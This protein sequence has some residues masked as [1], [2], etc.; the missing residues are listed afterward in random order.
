L[1]LDTEKPFNLEPFQQLIAKAYF[2]GRLE[3]VAILPFGNAKSTLLA[4][5]G[6]YHMLTTD[7]AECIVAAS[8]ADQAGIIFDQMAGLI[9]R[10][11][12]PLDARRAIRAI[13]HKPIP[14]G[15]DDRGRPRFK[16]LLG[17]I[18]VISADVKK[19]SGAIPTLVLVD[20]LQAH[21]DGYLYNMFRGRLNKRGA[22]M[23][24][25][26]N[27]G[28]DKDSFL[29]QLRQ[30]AHDHESFTRE[31]MMNHALAGSLE[32]F[33]WCLGEG[34]DPHDITTVKLANPLDHITEASLQEWHD[35]LGLV[36]AEWLRGAC[37][38]WTPTQ[39]PFIS[40]EMWDGLRVDIG[41]LE[42]GDDV[43]LAVRTGAGHGIGIASPRAGGR[44][45][46]SGISLPPPRSGRES[47]A[48]AEA[49]LRELCD[50]YN[51][52]VIAYDGDQF[53]RSAELLEQEGLPMN[54]VPQRPQRLA[55][56][57]STFW[58]LVSGGLLS[59]DGDTVLRD[60][61]LETS[62]T[63]TTSGWRINP[64]ANT[65]VVAAIAIACHEATR[66][67]D[68]TPAFVAL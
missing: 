36:E 1:T 18:R 13:Y 44:V 15:V 34:D 57:T 25:I 20:E 45:A 28:W 50:N 64:N 53:R 31:G 46:V 39:N 52:L 16:R 58:R 27:A 47:L 19:N 59:H 60:R 22:Q 12:L 51:V 68:E 37:G 17:R 38:L 54:E 10:S 33:E 4:A 5:L 14:D 26:S 61:V 40:P 21:P 66:L 32:F 3:I 7:R 35:T 24:T 62:T 42:D 55:Q 56:A 8:A 2:S 23:V 9:D 41:G 29:A 30:R 6:L 65:A 49:V 11:G 63:E 48:K 43:V 67:P